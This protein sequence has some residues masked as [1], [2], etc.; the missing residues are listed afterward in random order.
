MIGS[1]IGIVVMP[2]ILP[3]TDLPI[4]Q[5]AAVLQVLP[6]DRDTGR[7]NNL[8]LANASNIKVNREC[9]P[10]QGTAV[11][12]TP[13]D[14]QALRGVLAQKPS[15]CRGTQHRL[16]PPST[17]TADHSAEFLANRV[18]RTPAGATRVVLRQPLAGDLS[19]EVD[20]SL[21]HE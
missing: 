9:L 14:S 4:S 17:A 6:G 11:V 12:L 13:H 7:V 2:T 16:I 21:T 3:L 20:G 18:D 10:A 1:S 8:R 19:Q 15:G 5:T